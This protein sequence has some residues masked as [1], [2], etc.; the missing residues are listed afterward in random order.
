[1]C[2][3]RQIDFICFAHI[4]KLN[5][6]FT[7]RLLTL[8]KDG[9][10]PRSEIPASFAEGRAQFIE[11]L[12]PALISSRSNWWIM[13]FPNPEPT[14]FDSTQLCY[15]QWTLFPLCGITAN[16]R[17]GCSFKGKIDNGKKIASPYGG[18]PGSGDYY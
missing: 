9:K 10:Q 12:S 7:L 11:M 14:I 4:V 1:M 15:N 8:P 3:M 17:G 16:K 5:I 6:S 2:N 18:S 13:G